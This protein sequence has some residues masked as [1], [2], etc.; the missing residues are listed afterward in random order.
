M[1]RRVLSFLLALTLCFS[2]L[3]VSAMAEDAAASPSPAAA[4]TAPTEV[5]KDELAPTPTATE[6]S[7][8]TAEVTPAPTASVEDEEDAGEENDSVIMPVKPAGDGETDGIAAMNAGDENGIEVQV[9]VGSPVAKVGDTEY[10]TLDEILAEMEPVKI[11]LLGNVSENITVYA[12]TTINMAGF[13]ITGSIDATDS[14][15]LTNGTVTGNVKVDGGTFTM[16]APSGASAAINGGLKVISGSCSVSGA[17]VGVSGTLYF[18]GSSMTITGTTRAVSLTAEA[19]PTGKMFYGSAAVDGST[20]EKAVFADGTYKVGGEAAKKLS[21]VQAGG[22]SEP[23]TK[24]TLTIT[25]TKTDVTAGDPATFTVTYTGEDTLKAYIQNNGLDT[26]FTVTQ[27]N[28]GDGTYT[29]TVE[30][31]KETPGGEYTLYVHEVNNTFVQ[32]KATI[33]V[34]GFYQAELIGKGKYEYFS[35][36]LDA[37]KDGDTVK[38]LKDIDG[39]FNIMKS[40]ALDLNGNSWNGAATLYQNSTLT[41]MGSGTVA[42]VTLGGKLDIQNDGVK[43]NA[44]NVTSAPSPAMS[45]KHGTFGTIT[46]TAANIT[47]SD[48]L[49][50][51]YAF[52]YRD[53]N[54]DI[55]EN[56]KVAKLTNVTVKTHEHHIVDGKCAC[57]ATCLHTKWKNGVCLD[58]DRT[59]AHEDIDTSNYTCKTCGAELTASLTA[60]GSTTYYIGLADALNA[61]GDAGRGTCTVTLLKNAAVETVKDGGEM[62][63]A[64]ATIAPGHGSS[65]RVLDLNGHSIT[66]GGRIDAGNYG[67]EGYLTVTGSGTVDTEIVVNDGSLK[68]STFTGTISTVTIDSGSISS[69]AGTNWR[70]GTLN[71]DNERS[72][73]SLCSGT[74]G[75]ITANNPNITAANLL[76]QGYVFQNADGSYGDK[77]TPVDGLTEVTVVKCD[78]NGYTSGACRYCG[79][80]M[81]A[82]LTL[83][84]NTVLY[85]SLKDAVTAAQTEENTGCTVTLLKDISGSDM[86]VNAGHFTL[87]LGGNRLYRDYGTLLTLSL[88]SNLTVTNGTLD[89][90]NA[91]AVSVVG[92]ASLRL[93]G[94][95]KVSGISWE[96]TGALKIEPD[97]VF[98]IQ[99]SD[100]NQHKVRLAA[101]GANLGVFY[102]EGIAFKEYKADGTTGDFVV[103]DRTA[104]HYSTDDLIAVEHWNHDYKDGVCTQ[105]GKPCPGHDDYDSSGF[106]HTCAQYARV[107]RIEREYYKTLPEAIAAAQKQDGCTI[108]LLCDINLP[109]GEGLTISEGT[110]TLDLSGKFLTKKDADTALTFTGD[111]AVTLKNGTLMTDNSSREGILLSAG[112]NLTIENMNV[113][114]WIVLG[115]EMNDNAKLTLVSGSIKVIDNQ[116]GVA[117]KD[118]L[119]PGKRLRHPHNTEPITLSVISADKELHSVDIERCD[120]H[121]EYIV[122]TANAR[123]TCE[124]CGTACPHI[125]TDLDGNCET[126]GLKMA[127]TISFTDIYG[128]PSVCFRATDAEMLA[129]VAEFT[130]EG[131]TNI[132]AMMEDSKSLKVPLTVSAG[133]F[134]LDLSGKSLGGWTDALLLTGSAN[135]TLTNG[136]LYADNSGALGVRVK[137]GASLTVTDSITV[138]GALVVEET[139][140]TVTLRGGKFQQIKTQNRANNLAGLLA[141]GYRYDIIG[142]DGAATPQSYTAMQGF[143]DVE[144]NGYIAAVA[145]DPHKF[146]TDLVC[147]YCNIGCRGDHTYDDSGK[148]TI[149]GYTCPH[150]DVTESGNTAVCNTCKADMAVK[151]TNGETVIYLAKTIE[152]RYT[153]LGYRQEIDVTMRDAFNS[154]ADNGIITLLA[155]ELDAWADVS[156]K[157]VTLDFNDHWL[158]ENGIDFGST[159]PTTVIL[160]GSGGTITPEGVGPS[161]GAFWLRDGAVMKTDGFTGTIGRLTVSGS[162]ARAELSS[163]TYGTIRY[164]S[165]GTEEAKTSIVGVWLAEGY[166]F[167]YV[168]SGEHVPYDTTLSSAEVPGGTYQIDN[169]TVVKCDHNGTNGF[170][171]NST[172]CPYC[173]APAV[174][175]TQ[176]NLPESAGNPWR[177]FADLQAAL[178]SDRVGGSVVRLLADVAGDYTISG[179]TYTGLDLNGY[180][181]NGT[182]YVTGGEKDTTFSNSGSTGT[183]GT[184]V[185]SAGAKLAGS[186]APAVI[187]TLKLAE[188]ATWA[189][190]LQL[191][192]LGYKVYTNYPDLSGYKWYAPTDVTGTELHNVTIDNLPITSSTL[193]LKANGKNVS[194]VEPGTTVQLCAYCNTSG[195]SVAFYVGKQEGNGYNY[196]QL[197][198]DKVEYKKIGTTWYYVAEYTFSERGEYNIYFTAIKEGYSAASADKKLTVTKASIPADAITAPTVNPLTYNGQ[199]QKLVTPGVLDAKYGTMVYSLSRSASSFSTEIP[200][201]TDA[202]TYKVYYK[203]L[204]NDDY[205]DGNRTYTLTVTIGPKTLYLVN[206]TLAEKIYDGTADAVITEAMFAGLVD[207][208]TLTIG[209]DYT[210]V[211][212]F[213]D[214]ITGNIDANA[215]DGKMAS[216]TVKLTGNVKNYMLNSGD[217]STLVMSKCTI[218]KATA[219]AATPGKLYVY[220]NLA[221]TYEVELPALPELESPKTYGDNVSYNWPGSSLSE[222]Y[223]NGGIELKPGIL[224]LP[225]LKNQTNKEGSIGTAYVTVVTDNYEDFKLE[226]N[227]FAKNRITPGVNVLSASD[228]TYGQPLSESTLSFVLNGAYDPTT[229]DP[230]EGTLRWKD[231]SIVPGIN[232]DDNWYVWE[233]IPADKYDGKY[234][235]VTGDVYVKVNP[236][237]LTGVSVTQTGTL[238]YNGTAQI[239]KVNAAATAVNGQKVTFTYSASENGTYGAA[240]PAFTDAGTYTVYYKAN[241][242]GHTE[243]TGSFTVTIDPMEIARTTF[244]K[245]LSKTYDGTAVFALDATEKASCLKFYDAHNQEVSVPADAYE[246]S[247]VRALVMNAEGGYVDS[248]EAGSKSII[249]HTVKLT[250]KNYVLHH[251]DYNPTDE[252]TCRDHNSA[253]VTITKA[254]APVISTMLELHVTNGIE[255]TY[256]LELGMLLPELTMPCEFGTVTYGLSSVVLNADYYDGTAKI[257]NSKLLLPIKA[258][259]SKVGPL[260]KVTVEVGSTNYETFELTIPVFSKEKLVPV[261]DGTVSATDIT[262]GQTLADSTLTVTGTMKC[263]LTGN[264][265]TGTFAWKNPDAVPDAGGYEAE[266]A[267]TPAASYG[268]EYTVVTGKV[269]VKVNKADPTFTAPTANTLTYNG[270]EQTLLTTG[271]AAGG[272]MLYRLGDTGEFTTGIPTGKDAGTYTV[273]YKVAGD[274]NHNDTA[275]KS[276]TVTIDPMPLTGVIH[277]DPISKAY[278]G[279]ATAELLP[280]MVKFISKAAGRSD[281]TLPDTALTITNARFTMLQADKSYK[282]SPEVGDGKSLAFTLTLTSSN[283]VFEGKP[284]IRTDDCDIA[285]DDT[286]RFTITKAAAPAVTPGELTV[287]NGLHKTYS[288]DLSTLLPSLADPCEYGTVVYGAPAANLGV[289]TFVTRVNNKTGALTLEVVDRNSTDEGSFGTITV[290]V[291]TA[292]YAD[293]TLTINVGAVNKTVPVLDGEVSASSITYGQ[294]LNDSTI[295]GKMKDPTTGAEVTGTFAWKNGAVKPI[296][297]G[298]RAEW[299]FTPDVPEYAVTTGIVSVKVNRKNI[300]GAAVTLKS[301]SV[302]YDGTEKSPELESVVLDGVTLIN[303]QDYDYVY[304]C[305]RGTDVGQYG[306]TVVGYNNYEGEVTVYM[307]ITPRTVTAPTI[308]VS[309]APFIYTGSA[310]TPEVT[311]TDDLGRVIDPTEYSVSYKDNTNAGT[312]TITVTD[313]DGGNYTVSGSTTFEIEKTMQTV[314]AGNV[315]GVYGETGKAVVVTAAIGDVTFVSSDESV[316]TADAAGALA[317]H[318]SGTAEIIVRAAGDANHYGAQTKI[319]VTVAKAPVTI[320][321]NDKAVYRGL[322]APSLADPKAGTDYTITGLLGGDTLSGITVRLAYAQTPNTARVGKTEIVL[323]VTGEDARYAVTAENGTLTVSNRSFDTVVE[324]SEN[325][326]IT[327]DTGKSTA[328]GGDQTWRI[329]PKP[330]YATA[331]VIVDG[332]HVGPVSE[333]TFKNVRE[334]HTI[335]AVFMPIAG[336]PQNGVDVGN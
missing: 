231:G 164:T 118:I 107:A 325:G 191:S 196:F 136:S 266:W 82:K 39:T 303:G 192:N 41:L 114:G 139:A 243:T 264:T 19:E 121:G 62:V 219:P 245:N 302:V 117:W 249:E 269:T 281:I 14:L 91:Y 4:A 223:Y 52:Y 262:Y 202:G 199:P 13:S 34:T 150:S 120:P 22:S 47:A 294:T 28:S 140:G 89:A 227:V 126:C 305:A 61:A 66:G 156:G 296:A 165:G 135:V 100:G 63:T 232:A 159:G 2:L 128:N 16:T 60:N 46:I 43:V 270:K 285:T 310:V 51:G 327:S 112:A 200:T 217:S 162:A 189:N 157:T 334:K 233:F 197:S 45:L 210:A 32:A 158:S 12:T 263:P 279:T 113:V 138:D 134:T 183:V 291:T 212:E 10:A 316:V 64:N 286:S 44:L 55:V 7:A 57:G 234:A 53:I 92:G 194:S 267:F 168:E 1:K 295:T 133:T 283:Y 318:K 83:G 6:K 26:N 80:V 330:G 240:V 106:C 59:C 220:N 265:L 130:A 176:L 96:S 261:L 161:I 37:A 213:A 170:D 293:I 319:T 124:Y 15:T 288:F 218:K 258:A 154:T 171:I 24:P 109:D 204:G 95:V 300:T 67:E 132:L 228:I 65:D 268:G 40:V 85:T 298:Y 71:M 103:L 54:R 299:T 125:N 229:G 181:I 122:D 284:E 187:G 307:S 207:G 74:I 116:K 225:I 280:S 239:A 105:C 36:A 214:G 86:L 5:K 141:P 312:A 237:A 17:Q 123:A 301:D 90:A 320:R 70:I 58:C 75:A 271:T 247:N 201:K 272:T 104:Q 3:P 137:D 99:R 21:N 42:E 259:D 254:A 129:S 190:I 311:V 221:K 155:D 108:T 180:S 143:A 167:R 246:I 315:S 27:K 332:E 323:T 308:T 203:V 198:G 253:T 111:A 222:N 23:V 252:W 81:E 333:W 163:G 84:A 94:T 241:S 331:D 193:S 9:A 72:R 20:A 314:A 257:E 317:F 25:P 313:N 277:V 173:G 73:G 68:L 88:D 35:R 282:E 30:T 250:S 153:S 119:A 186:G 287:T 169:V 48:L 148:C 329:T 326:N 144:A 242:T 8:P 98:Q 142:E 185:A 205:K 76:A 304:G 147:E 177:K 79:E 18:D 11:T 182:V 188:G 145:C 146:D 306:L 77:T 336:N 275:E 49:A 97:A 31:S 215:G 224:S 160:T 78:H 292:N 87:D 230:V 278:D 226:I 115:S 273:Y 152:V 178:D 175:Y 274:S 29:F 238:T 297:G 335:E 166:A 321:A 208:D 172:S 290:T 256:E 216:V 33:S 235:I 179:T 276:I 244:V 260:G 69:D 93:T 206:A 209:T 131:D 184:V 251:P 174:V 328:E 50:D 195:A 289:G 101:E 211:G 324:P 236:A 56:G 102:T 110:F 149:C 322:A 127:W 309:G 255:K 38:L 151:V 248:P